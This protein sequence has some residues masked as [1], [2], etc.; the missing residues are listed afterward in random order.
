MV[1]KCAQNYHRGVV[2]YVGVLSCVVYGSPLIFP[3]NSDPLSYPV[4]SPPSHAVLCPHCAE[5]TVIDFATDDGHRRR[6]GCQHQ[7][8]RAVRPQ[9]RGGGGLEQGKPT[10]EKRLSVL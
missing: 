5:L 7:E 1:S 9:D 2:S 4:S 3:C 8:L 10:L 6:Q